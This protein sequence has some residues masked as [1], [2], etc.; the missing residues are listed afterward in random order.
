MM[1]GRRTFHFKGQASSQEVILMNSVESVYRSTDE[2]MDTPCHQQITKNPAQSS[3]VSDVS[4][5]MATFDYNINCD[6]FH[7]LYQT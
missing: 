6:L 4:H 1:T 7:Y 5:F 2:R 3:T